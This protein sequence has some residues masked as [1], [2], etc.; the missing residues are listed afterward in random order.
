VAKIKEIRILEPKVKEVKKEKPKEEPEEEE[1]EEFFEDDSDFVPESSRTNLRK[2][3]L[4]SSG[5]VKDNLEQMVWD[6]VRDEKKEEV[7]FGEQDVYKGT[8]GMYADSKNLYSGSGDKENKGQDFN[9]LKANSGSE[10]EGPYKSVIE[11]RRDNGPLDDSLD[12]RKR[13]SRR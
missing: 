2:V 1:G 6:V 7:K 13:P 12:M 9:G 11:E 3:I 10:N 5:G 4:D 8:N